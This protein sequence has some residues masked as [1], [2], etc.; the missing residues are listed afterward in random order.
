MIKLPKAVVTALDTLG[1]SGLKKA[2]LLKAAHGNYY[3]LTGE[4]AVFKAVSDY[5]EQSDENLEKVVSGIINGYSAL[6]F[7]DYADK[8]NEIC[9][10]ILRINLDSEHAAWLDLS[11]HVGSLNISVAE[12]KAN[13][14]ERL[15]SSETIYLEDLL[16]EKQAAIV[17]RLKAFVQ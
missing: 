6:S 13:Y 10:L 12:S 11:G 1:E 3:G 16:G 15:Y 2:E 9:T 14:R 17:E 4:K 7:D 5:S 8:F